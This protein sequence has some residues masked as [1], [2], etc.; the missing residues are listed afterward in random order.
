MG[1]EESM[2]RALWYKV[3]RGSVYAGAV[4]GMEVLQGDTQWG[5]L[6]SLLAIPVLGAVGKTIRQLKPD[7]AKYIFV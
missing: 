6:I 3:L 2:T 1:E 4:G 5:S 7:W